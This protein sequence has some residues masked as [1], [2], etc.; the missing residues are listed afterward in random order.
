LE[1]STVHLPLSIFCLVIA[2]TD[3]SGWQSNGNRSREANG[4]VSLSKIADLISTPRWNAT[5]KKYIRIRG[6]ISVVSGM[7][8]SEVTNPKDKS[9]S[10]EDESAGI[11]IRVQQAVDEGLLQDTSVLDELQAGIEAEIEGSLAPGG[12]APV[13]LPR[14]IKVLG[15]GKLQP[16]IRPDL[17]DF[18]RGAHIMRRVTVGGVVQN[19]TDDSPGWLVRVETGAGH[20]L[21]RLPKTVDF[22]QDKLMDAEIQVTG[23][24]G[25][26]RNWRS[27][28]VC[29]RVMIASAADVEIVRSPSEDPFKA[30]RVRVD[31]LDGFSLEGRSLHRRRF[32]GAVTYYDGDRILYVVN[33]D[34][35]VRLELNQP[36]TDQ[37]IRVGDVVEVSGFI[38][39]TRYLRGLRGCRVRQMGMRSEMPPVKTT[40]SKIIADHLVPVWKQ[41][42]TKT[43]DGRVVTLEG[44]V[45]GF[46]TA[47]D[48]SNNRIEVKCDDGT[49]TA[50][51]REPMEELLTGSTVELTGV[52]TISYATSDTTSQ[53]AEPN[54]VD[55]LLRS[56]DD[57]RITSQPSWW[58]VKRIS[59]A[60]AL[61]VL[62]A[63]LAVGWAVTLNRRVA[64]QTQQLASEM[65]SRRDAAIEFKA[66][67]RERT[68][69][70]ANIHDTVL[71]T[72]AG[73][74][75]QLDACSQSTQEDSAAQGY[76]KTASRMVQGGQEDLRNVVS[77][78]HCLPLADQSFGESVRRVVQRLQRTGTLNRNAKGSDTSESRNGDDLSRL[79]MH[80]DD[81][82]SITVHCAEDLPKLADFIAGNLLLLIQE[83]T[84]NAIKH[85][86]ANSIAI[87]VGTIDNGSRMLITVEDDG[88]GFDNKSRPRQSDGHFGLETMKGRA[89]RIGGSL[90]VESELGKGTTITA[91]A[92]LKSFDEAMT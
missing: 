86:D 36:A 83:A 5:A 30:E 44:E 89:E 84:R 64:K 45:L 49:F 1:R 67:I 19:V 55:L 81:Q 57:I 47:T 25:A 73:I 76:L 70:A 38:D 71:Q 88:R 42:L 90:T 87:T 41:V 6:T 39:A 11:W 27:Q 18:F 28:F 58:T 15:R 35:G 8:G 62:F 37:N 3:A 43:F 69:L 40:V 60:L 13:V 56:K 92:P 24:G 7:V 85:S 59:G 10:L 91:T 22:T 34:I 23:V 80:G 2:A 12:F 20:F 54:G 48:N 82:A 46:D 78:L 31:E 51:L 26:S 21:T 33:D 75:C 32:E 4:T 65:G 77:A 29:P 63:G 53:L 66:A 16:A 68:Q 52:A 17:K 72:L 50:S 79:G 74:G 14:R 61:S 9:F